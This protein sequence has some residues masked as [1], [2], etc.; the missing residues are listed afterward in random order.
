[1]AACRSLFD[2]TKR[3]SV[4]LSS[5]PVEASIANAERISDELATDSPTVV[6]QALPAN[7]EMR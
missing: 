1:M 5:A 3:R 7:R 6:R 4:M 2:L